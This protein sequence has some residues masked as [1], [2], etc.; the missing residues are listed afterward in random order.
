MALCEQEA[1]TTL[2]WVTGLQQSEDEEI[3][4]TA[5]AA[6]S[7]GTST[8][9]LAPPPLEEQPPPLEA[10]VLEPEA[11]PPTIEPQKPGVVTVIEDKFV[12]TD[13]VTII[14][15]DSSFLVDRLKDYAGGGSPPKRKPP[16]PRPPGMTPP[17]MRMKRIKQEQGPPELTPAIGVPQASGANTNFEHQ[18]M[19]VLAAEGTPQR[20]YKPR[21]P[22]KKMKLEGAGDALESP[23]AY[24]SL[25]P[26]PLGASDLKAENVKG[27]FN[28]PYCP[29]TFTESVELYKHLAAHHN[30]PKAINRRARRR[31]TIIIT[32]D[33]QQVVE[34]GAP[35]RKPGAK[36]RYVRKVE[37][38]EE[39]E[40]Q[41][42]EQPQYV[43]Q[44][45]WYSFNN[46]SVCMCLYASM[47]M[48]MYQ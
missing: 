45:V 10:P 30:L 35:N 44:Q 17:G 48:C 23:S 22:L 21:H 16:P 33:G 19:P 9:V 29:E 20:N 26:K 34:N 3:A 38:T 8:E 43:V 14:I 11:P 1:Q 32:D 25:R 5:I 13:P 7:V 2:V 15:G 18:E 41:E 40:D 4:A 37:R 31:G 46:L 28:C 6:P 12:Q 24:T 47:C 27:R 36:R 39:G 42:E